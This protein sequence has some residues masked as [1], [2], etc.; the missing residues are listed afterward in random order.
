MVEKSTLFLVIFTSLVLVLSFKDLVLIKNSTSSEET[1]LES[2]KPI[3]L[4]KEL[5]LDDNKNK[6]DDFEN[7][8]N[9]DD[10]EQSSNVEEK[11]SDDMPK[12][13]PSLKMKSNVQTLKFLYCF[14]CGYKNAFEQYSQ[15]I[16][17]RFPEL[18]IIGENYTP[19][20]HRL[21]LAQ[22]LSVLK[23]VIIGFIISGT[24]PFTYFN[25]A[26]PNVFTW[27]TQNKFYSCLMIFF[28]SN[29]IET[30][31]ISSGAFEIYLNGMQIWS[32]L[33]SDRIP[34]E[35]EL[36]QIL[37]MNFNFET[38]KNNAFGSGS[39]NVKF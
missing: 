26:T 19:G 24:S 20:K 18:N 35:K 2:G 31:L 39:S 10:F 15:L 38:E 17:S 36:M 23:M 1:N 5:K 11:I 37:D 32:K 13:I 25:L 30:S 8:E 6:L 21:I 12:K 29:A 22:V 3:S 16:K 9:S 28:L 4:E 7:D 14:S 27:A 34:H 33:E